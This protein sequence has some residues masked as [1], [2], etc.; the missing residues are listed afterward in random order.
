MHLLRTIG[1]LCC[2]SS[3]LAQSGVRDQV[4]PSPGAGQLANF[5]VSNPANVWQQQV[6]AGVAG[7]L[8]GL[9]LRITGPAGA[10]VTLRVRPGAGWST[11]P[12][13]FQT[14]LQKSS[15][16]SE[17]LF[18]DASA[19]HF[20]LVVGQRFVLELQGDGSLG[21]ID[22][23][24]VP[25]SQGAPQY[26]EP[27]FLSGPSC[28]ASC[29]WR[30]GFE[31][32]VSDGDVTSFCHGVGCPCGNDTGSAGCRN[33]TGAGA[34]LY[35]TI[36]TTSVAAD[37]LELVAA[38]LPTSVSGIVFLGSTQIRAPFADGLRCAGGLTKRYGVAV[39]NTSGAITFTEL[40]SQS[41]GLVIAGSS[42]VLQAWYRDPSGPCLRTANLT[43]ALLIVFVP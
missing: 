13:A 30:I 31:T 3:A 41:G 6:R 15:A 25:P 18:V 12:A 4:S 39:S 7:E 17:E 42:W 19:A 33:S 36:G 32:Y 8:V 35:P 20:A 40:A 28:Y 37:D 38:S 23:S 16:S 26:S 34:M 24:Y 22:G 43:N 10:R 27:L 1:L 21:G 5:A 14:T 9:R 11:G 29:G 2:A